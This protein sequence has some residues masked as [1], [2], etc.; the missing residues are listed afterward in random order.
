VMPLLEIVR[1][2]KTSTQIIVDLINVGKNIKKSP[3]SGGK[4]HRLCCQLNVLSIHSIGSYV[5][6][7]WCKYL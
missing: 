1:T 2:E 5:G 6:N 4:L 7:S 3:Y